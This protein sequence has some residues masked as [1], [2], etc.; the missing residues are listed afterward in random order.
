MVFCSLRNKADTKSL[1]LCLTREFLPKLEKGK[2]GPR[3]G[4]EGAWRQ[5][6]EGRDGCLESAEQSVR[7][8]GNFEIRLRILF[9]LIFYQKDQ[10]LSD[11]EVLLFYCYNLTSTHT[12]S[13]H[14]ISDPLSSSPLRVTFKSSFSSQPQL[15]PCLNC[16]NL[17][18]LFILILHS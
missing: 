6:A 16:F 17:Q 10:P 13:C 4:G 2:A 12:V 5:G 11:E 8:R 18:V 14:Y 3:V 7:G 15:V 9:Y 1:H